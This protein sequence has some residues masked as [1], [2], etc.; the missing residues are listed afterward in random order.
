MT[1]NA[2]M[3]KTPFHADAMFK[4]ADVDAFVEFLAK[5]ISDEK[6]HELITEL[7]KKLKPEMVERLTDPAYFTSV[8]RIIT[9]AAAIVLCAK[10]VSDE[11]VYNQI[12]VKLNP[13]NELSDSNRR[14]L[15]A[16]LMADAT[17]DGSHVVMSSVYRRRIQ[18]ARKLA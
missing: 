11:V 9:N 17:F 1:A 15:Y 5:D 13:R 6:V 12:L 4:V 14:T 3:E 2:S 18:Q 7:G 10:T 8:K 16:Y